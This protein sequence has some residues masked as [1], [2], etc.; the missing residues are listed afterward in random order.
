MKISYNASE[1]LKKNEPA[2][3]VFAMSRAS[4]PGGRF[5]S[6]KSTVMNLSVIVRAVSGKSI[7]PRNSTT[8][9]CSLPLVSARRL[10]PVSA[11][12]SSCENRA[13]SPAAKDSGVMYF[14]SYRRHSLPELLIKA[15]L[16][17]IGTKK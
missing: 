3:P 1:P 8:A 4:I 15:L 9:L 7:S 12:V 13:A 14:V 6:K 2:L 5:L 10:L 11:I 16:S 17:L